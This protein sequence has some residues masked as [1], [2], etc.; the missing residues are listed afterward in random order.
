MARME[1]ELEALFGIGQ[2]VELRTP[3]DL[4]R[5]FVADVIASSE[6]LYAA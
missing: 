5:R 6:L 2:E 4:S 1:F 3:D